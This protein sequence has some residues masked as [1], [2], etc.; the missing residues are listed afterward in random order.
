MSQI[1]AEYRIVK[2]VNGD[3]VISEIRGLEDTT[4]DV[5]FLV[6][7][8]Q[9]QTFQVPTSETQTVALRK[10]APY[11]DDASV[12]VSLRNVISISSVKN[13]LLQYYINIAEQQRDS[14]EPFMDDVEECGV[15]EL[16][17]AEENDSLTQETLIEMLKARKS[18]VH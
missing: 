12:P 9:I 10:W 15:Q 16:V 3:D 17:D 18:T 6:D 14:G 1:E 7:A 13:D 5:I 11:T 2:F 4:N 8:Y